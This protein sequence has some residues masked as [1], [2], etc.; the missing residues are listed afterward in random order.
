MTTL[1]PPSSFLSLWEQRSSSCTFRPH[2]PLLLFLT[3]LP[4]CYGLGSGCRGNQAGLC[5]APSGRVSPVAPV[6]SSVALQAS[7]ENPS[8]LRAA[9]AHTCTEA[10]QSCDLHPDS[11][12][13]VSA[14]CNEALADQQTPSSPSSQLSVSFSSYQSLGQFQAPPPPPVN[15]LDVKEPKT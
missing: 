10:C 13:C 9:C 5:S 15:L 7:W 12:I 3:F 14:A 11:I 1:P 8:W 6:S 4:F 2:T